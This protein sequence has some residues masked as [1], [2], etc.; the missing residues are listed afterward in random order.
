MR[1]TPTEGW[2]VEWSKHKNNDVKEIEFVL[3]RNGN[4]SINLMRSRQKMIT[5]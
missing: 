2:R 5:E 3:Y 1:Q 4:K